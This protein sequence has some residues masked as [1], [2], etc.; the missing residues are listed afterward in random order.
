MINDCTDGNIKQMESG[1]STFEHWF[2]EINAKKGTKC[3]D[4]IKQ[5]VDEGLSIIEAQD[6]AEADLN[7]Q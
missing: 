7:G 4:F 3:K 2:E 5:Y 6:K 1:S